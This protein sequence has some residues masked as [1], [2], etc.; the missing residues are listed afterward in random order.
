M[1]QV[2][3]QRYLQRLGIAD[4]GPPSAAGLRALHAAHVER[5][6]FETLEIHL[7]RAT[8]VDPH[9]S[10]ARILR[11][12]GGYCFHLNGAFATLLQA[13]GYTVSWHRGGVHSTSRTPPPGA[14]GDHLTLTVACEGQ[15]W[16]VDVGLG[17]ALHEPLPLR[18]ATYRQG[19]FT[20]GLTRSGVEPGGWRFDHDPRGTFVGMDF[21]L[22][23]AGPGDFI[24]L[25]R[26][27]STSP[28]SGFVRIVSAMRRDTR[29]V[30]ALEGCILSRTDSTGRNQRELERASDWFGALADV[31]GLALDDATADERTVLWANVYSK[32]QA[33]KARR[34]C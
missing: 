9:E 12:R 18:A 32:H 5:V 30:D 16:F 31:F 6:P 27:L 21:S 19:P 29:G 23:P 20:Y 28:D 10:I 17:D 1:Q 34:N 24:R 26:E 13:L 33:W 15:S 8:T 25:H 22:A 11:G 7:G 4:P 14:T 2:D 3:V